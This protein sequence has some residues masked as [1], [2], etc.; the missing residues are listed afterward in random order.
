M[1]RRAFLKAAAVM[2]ASIASGDVPEWT[3]GE[4]EEVMP[5]SE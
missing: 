3:K 5:C 1:T 4:P 2:A